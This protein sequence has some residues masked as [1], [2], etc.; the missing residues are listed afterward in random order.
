MDGAVLLLCEWYRRDG[1][2]DEAWGWPL[3]C[4][5]GRIRDF[6]LKKCLFPHPHPKEKSGPSFQVMEASFSAGAMVE[7]CKCRGVAPV[8]QTIILKCRAGGMISSQGLSSKLKVG[9]LFD[10]LPSSSWETGLCC[11]AWWVRPQGL[12][13]AAVRP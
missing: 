2:K 10:L 6:V 8:V 13:E 9:Q 11:R 7:G 12:A 4:I 5:G 1:T 3:P